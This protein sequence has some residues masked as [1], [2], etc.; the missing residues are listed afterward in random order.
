MPS[1]NR[2]S[3]WT[4]QWLAEGRDR[5]SR[6]SSRA[7]ITTKRFSSRRPTIG[8]P[9]D[10]RRVDRPSGR[11]EFRPLELSIYL[12]GNELPMLPVFAEVL[13]QDDASVQTPPQSL[14]KA[15]SESMLSRP[16]TSFSIPRKPVAAG[17]T[18]SLDGSQSNLHSRYPSS[19]LNQVL[20]T[21]P[22]GRRPS[23]ATSQSTQ[24]FLDSL[25]VRLPQS[26]G[27]LRS[28]TSPE[29][30]YT[31][32][33]RASEQNIRLRTHL[34]EREQIERQLPDCDTILEEKPSE[35]SKITNTSPIF[36]HGNSADNFLRRRLNPQLLDAADLFVT[37]P[38]A[39]SQSQ[40]SLAKLN[41]RYSPEPASPTRARV[42]Q[43]LLRSQTSLPMS[44]PSCWPNKDE[45]PSGYRTL[46]ST[47]DRAST[48]SSFYSEHTVHGTPDLATPWTTPRSSPHRKGH[49]LSSEKTFDAGQSREPVD[50]KDAATFIRV[51]LAV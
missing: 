46:W 51:G 47:R 4:S 25:D 39:Y 28:K 50:H 37:P 35:E 36:G 22:T 34:E 40:A 23:I 16:S 42:S 41:A 27:R 9:S 48:V 44:A 45:S 32:Y 6:A 17:R 30:I 12:P 24:D 18:F 31:L 33:R 11:A 49:S 21:Q 26:P 1:E 2:N 38:P 5:A 19:D 8:A 7:S 29:P 15:R 3:H 20:T 43:W 13:A 14:T 10:F